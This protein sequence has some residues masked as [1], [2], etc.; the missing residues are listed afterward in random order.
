MTLEV[1]SGRLLEG[2]KLPGRLTQ[3][4]NVECLQWSGSSTGATD[5]VRSARSGKACYESCPAHAIQD[6]VLN[7]ISRLRVEY[8]EMLTRALSP[9]PGESSS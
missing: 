6:S 7:S 2:L 3:L 4:P 9:E 8:G 1:G 5:I